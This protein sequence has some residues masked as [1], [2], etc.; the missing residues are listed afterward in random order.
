[1]NSR[2][3]KTKRILVVEDDD[4][5][6]RALGRCL[7]A[8]G[9]TNVELIE[10]VEGALIKL[11]RPGYDCIVSDL[12]MRPGSCDG[13][14]FLEAVRNN[15]L[16]RRVPFILMSAQDDPE[17]KESALA[18]G[19]TKFLKKPFSAECLIASLEVALA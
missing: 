15:G 10:N 1:M 8:Y 9:F 17:L 14:H 2:D 12:T 4:S 5:F 19:A 16:Y 18:R 3:P 6:S 7:A 11:L 13:W